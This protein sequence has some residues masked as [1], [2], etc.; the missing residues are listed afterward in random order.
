MKRIVCLIL[1]FARQGAKQIRRDGREGWLL[2]E[3][4]S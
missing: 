2:R 4:K 3:E 1:W